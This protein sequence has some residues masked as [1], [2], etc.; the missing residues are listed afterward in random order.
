VL[1]ASAR[2]MGR[3]DA[4]VNP[5]APVSPVCTGPSDLTESGPVR[6]VRHARARHED[7][8]DRVRSRG[9]SPPAT[10]SAAGGMT[11]SP[12]APSSSRGRLGSAPWSR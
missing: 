9:P 8:D 7:A 12:P 2:S 10:K 4:Q 6:T 1:R 3:I 5:R 11:S